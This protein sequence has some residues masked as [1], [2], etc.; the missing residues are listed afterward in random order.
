MVERA[1][2][3]CFCSP[4]FLVTVGRRAHEDDLSLTRGDDKVARR[5]QRL[6][7]TVAAGF[8]L[9]LPV[10]GIDARED[11]HIEA[12]DE[13]VVVHRTGDRVL[14]AVRPPQ[15][16]RREAVAVAGDLQG[17]SA[18]TGAR[19]KEDPVVADDYR[20]CRMVAAVPGPGGLPQQIAAIG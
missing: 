8:P 20:L 12:V 10:G 15:L 5:Q 18:D 2:L 7:V 17:Q 3:Y 13:S 6:A 1:S 16:T 4:D 9:Q 14:H 19:G 11:S